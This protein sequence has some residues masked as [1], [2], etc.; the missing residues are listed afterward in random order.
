MLRWSSRSARQDASEIDV[1]DD[2]LVTSVCRAPW[3]E[4]SASE[5]STR[6]DVMKTPHSRRYSSALSGSNI[7][8]EVTSRKC[9]Y[10][11]A[12]FARWAPTSRKAAPRGSASITNSV[13]MGEKPKYRPPTCDVRVRRFDHRAQ[14][15]RRYAAPVS[16]IVRREEAPVVEHVAG[17]GVGDVVGGEREALDCQVGSAPRSDHD[18]FRPRHGSRGS[19]ADSLR[20]PSPNSKRLNTTIASPRRNRIRLNDAPIRNTQRRLP[21]IVVSA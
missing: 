13:D 12:W 6:N 1:L 15:H 17:D 4:L 3:N 8:S 10:V 16:R 18:A 7:T 21:R 19:R 14:P 9:V 11:A 2:A 20:S 5:S